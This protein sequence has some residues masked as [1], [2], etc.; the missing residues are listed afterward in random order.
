MKLGVFT[1]LYSQKALPEMLDHVKSKGIEA[2]E[3]GTGGYPGNAHCPIDELLE[4]E[5]ALKNYQREF[6]SRDLTIS[7]LSCHSNPLHPNKEVAK[8]AHEKIGRAHV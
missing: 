3:I 8:E 1:V 7:A 4:N 2:V 6:T 5:T